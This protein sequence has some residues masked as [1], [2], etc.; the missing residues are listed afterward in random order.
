MSPGPSSPGEQLNPQQLELI[1]IDM[2]F[3]GFQ[4]GQS[5][6]EDMAQYG[7]LL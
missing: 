6:V 5:V 3:K 7:H 1:G 2:Y 4:K